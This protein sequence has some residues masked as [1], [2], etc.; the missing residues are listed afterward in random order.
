VKAF[1]IRF[2]FD[3]AGVTAFAAG[4]PADVTDEKLH[5]T[6]ENPDDTR[7]KAFHTGVIAFPER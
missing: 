3:R 2:T 5:C 7:V 6:G 4:S 1:R